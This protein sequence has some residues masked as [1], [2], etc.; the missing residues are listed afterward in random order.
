V[1]RHDFIT[2]L[3]GAAATRARRRGLADQFLLGIVSVMTRPNPVRCGKSRPVVLERPGALK[4][5]P[6]RESGQRKPA[7]GRAR[8]GNV[9]C[10]RTNSKLVRPCTSGLQS[11]AM[12][13]AEPTKLPNNSLTM[14]ESSNIASRVQAKSMSALCGKAN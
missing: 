13:L 11:V 2:L 10:R 7:V 1:K 14:G 4:D 9:R 12:C 5:A 6:T 3:G 8:H